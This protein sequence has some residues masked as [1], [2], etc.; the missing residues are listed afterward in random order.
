VELLNPGK[1]LPGLDVFNNEPEG[2]D[3]QVISELSALSNVYVTHH[4]GAS[5]EQAQNAVAEET[6]LII[7]DYI[8]LGNVRNWVNRCPTSS[9]T[10]QL[11]VR[12]FDKPGVLSK[13]LGFLS[14]EG[15][16]VQEVENVIFDGQETACCTIKLE[17]EPSAAVI[18]NLN[19]LH[20]EVIDV[21]LIKL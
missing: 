9:A 10:H 18:N 6:Y 3:G 13:V 17:L 20:D 4:I 7:H 12:H 21:S 15:I 11:I 16:N 14:G 1:F 19:T 5:T 8:K 2:K